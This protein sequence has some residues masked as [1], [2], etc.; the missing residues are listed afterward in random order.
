MSWLARFLAR[1]PRDLGPLKVT[2]YTKPV[3]PLCDEAKAV[4]HELAQEILFELEFVNIEEDPELFEAYR[5]DIPVIHVNGRKA[6]K[7]RLDPARFRL[8]LERTARHPPEDSEA[9]DR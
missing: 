4:V 5:Y 1:G 8:H 9:R 3:C 6:F 7:H 2:F